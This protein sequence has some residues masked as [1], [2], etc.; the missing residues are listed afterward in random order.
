VRAKKVFVHPPP[1]VRRRGEAAG[2]Q[3]L[4]VFAQSAHVLDFSKDSC[5]F[6][7]HGKILLSRL[8]G[9]D[10][11]FCICPKLALG[12]KILFTGLVGYALHTHKRRTVAHQFGLVGDIRI[13]RLHQLCPLR[14]I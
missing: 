3:K 12:D 13:H 14:N 10:S 5:D 6:L 11:Y 4:F 2:E 7:L 8:F 9:V 1:F